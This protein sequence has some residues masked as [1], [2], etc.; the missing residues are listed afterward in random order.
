MHILSLWRHRLPRPAAGEIRD[1]IAEL[2]HRVAVDRHVPHDCRICH[3]LLAELSTQRGMATGTT[4]SEP[5][6]NFFQLWNKSHEQFGTVIF[7]LFLIQPVIGH[8][9]HQS[10]KKTQM[11]GW[12]G[13][14]HVWYGRILILMGIIDGGMGLTLADN[15]VGGV[16]AY[17]VVMGFVGLLYL[18]V[19]MN[20][21]SKKEQPKEATAGS[22]KLSFR[23]DSFPASRDGQQEPKRAESAL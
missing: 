10:F 14:A 23:T 4:A 13:T 11:R 6:A 3:G 7:G 16:V 8:L 15:T 18:V 2:P 5:N 9:H 12:V 20:Y 21:W 17:S 1:V 19:I 22:G